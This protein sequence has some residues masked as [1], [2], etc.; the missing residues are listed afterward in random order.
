MKKYKWLGIIVSTMC[1]LVIF[2]SA[3]AQE[4]PV[5]KYEAAWESLVTHETPEWLREAK[6]GIYTHWGIYCYTATRGNATWNSHAA[7]V[8]PD[9]KA[10]MEFL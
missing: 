7:Y 9:S 5:K 6:F 1:L 3:C 2:Y 8:R 4:K 10:A